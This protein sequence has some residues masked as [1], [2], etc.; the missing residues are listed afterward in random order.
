MS[1]YILPEQQQ[2]RP[3]EYKRRSTIEDTISGEK[4]IIHFITDDDRSDE[5]KSGDDIIHFL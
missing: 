2:E 3:D 4:D 5:P 1:Q